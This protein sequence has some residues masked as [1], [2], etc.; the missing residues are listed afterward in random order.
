VSTVS[1]G[2]SVAYGSTVTTR[3]TTGDLGAALSY[4]RAHAVSGALVDGPLGPL[5][6]S[7]C[8]RARSGLPQGGAFLLGVS[9]RA[10]GRLGAVARHARHRRTESDRYAHRRAGPPTPST[11]ITAAAL[12]TLRVA[13]TGSGTYHAQPA[14]RGGRQTATCA[15]TA[16]TSRAF[17]AA[18]GTAYKPPPPTSTRDGQIDAGRPARSCSRTWAFLAEFRRRASEPARASTHVE[19]ETLRRRLVLPDRPRRATR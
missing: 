4:P 5:Q 8:G 14:G 12:H 2:V 11:R 19:L 3:P 6:R 15:W 13:G 16:S 9:V 17:M 1:G 10:G 7:R 18:R